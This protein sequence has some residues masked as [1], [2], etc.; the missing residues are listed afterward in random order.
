LF[1]EADVTPD[2]YRVLR[3][4]PGLKR[5]NAKPI[6]TFVP[7]EL[8]P[9]ALHPPTTGELRFSVD[10]WVHIT[11]GRYKD[12]IAC[13]K[14]LEDWGGLQL[15][16]LPRLSPPSATSTIPKRNKRSRS[17]PLPRP[18]AGLFDPTQIE[19][20]FNKTPKQT[21]PDIY[22]FGGQVFEYGLLLKVV[23][24]D[25]A[26]S[27]PVL[28]PFEIATLFLRSRH[29]AILRSKLPSPQDWAFTIDDF[30]EVDQDPSVSR[31]GHVKDVQPNFLEIELTDGTGR[32]ICDWYSVRKWMIPG[33]FVTVAAGPEI[34][35][36]GLVETLTPTHVSIVEEVVSTVDGVEQN[37]QVLKV[38]SISHFSDMKPDVLCFKEIH[39]SQKQCVCYQRTSHPHLPFTVSEP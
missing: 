39:C 10:Q 9:G 27:S 16:L 38:I 35:R 6:F 36:A 20:L 7:P 8:R 23:N 13:V 1:I 5:R 2:L 15:L 34:G 28:I 32:I 33:A 21:Q 4:I 24:A 14:E 22:R 19:R 30:V 17:C 25:S 29:P 12:D 26:S 11:R 37:V 3:T 18:D 31:Q